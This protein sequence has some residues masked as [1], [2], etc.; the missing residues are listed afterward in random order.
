MPLSQRES[1]TNRKL[2]GFKENIAKYNHFNRNTHNLEFHIRAKISPSRFRNGFKLVTQ[3]CR[4]LLGLKVISVCTVL[5][6]SWHLC[7]QT[8]DFFCQWNFANFANDD[9]HSGSEKKLNLSNQTNITQMKTLHVWN[10]I[11]KSIMNTGLTLCECNTFTFLY[12]SLSHRFWLEY[13]I[14][15]N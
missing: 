7:Q 14:E 15:M 5:Y 11:N 3:I 6:T 9:I 4:N 8:M 10:C 12:T 1:K 2:L 13:C